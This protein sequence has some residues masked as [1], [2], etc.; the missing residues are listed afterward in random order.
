[1]I[2]VHDPWA[3]PEE[4]LH[5]YGIVSSRQFPKEKFDA[6]VLAVAHSKLENLDFKNLL[7]SNGIVYDVKGVL[8]GE[9]DGKL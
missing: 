1:M 6:I 4:V 8:V 3:K 7:N 5:E 2:S 9:V